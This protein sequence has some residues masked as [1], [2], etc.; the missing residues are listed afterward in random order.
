M[1]RKMT[2]STFLLGVGGAA[3]LASF[4]MPASGQTGRRNVL[5]IIGHSQL[6]APSASSE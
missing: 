1:S 4:G 5:W 3:T 6:C 2:R